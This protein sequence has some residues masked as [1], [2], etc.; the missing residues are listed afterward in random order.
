MSWPLAMFTKKKG[1]QLQT[2]L[3]RD[4]KINKIIIIPWSWTKLLGNNVVMVLV[5]DHF[6]CCTDTMA[7]LTETHNRVFYAKNTTKKIKKNIRTANIFI[8]SQ[9]FDVTD[10][11]Y[12][13]IS[14]WAAS[15]FSSASWTLASILVGGKSIIRFCWKV[16]QGW[17][18]QCKT[19]TFQP[20]LL[21]LS[22]LWLAAWRFHPI[23]LWLIQC[24]A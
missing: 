1:K 24:F 8:I 5:T 12:L 15:T 10:W 14:P 22:P 6:F 9:R 20:F 7:Y 16:T 13:R 11:K 3:L 21:A 17:C 19:L 2:N 23:L 4:F 18:L